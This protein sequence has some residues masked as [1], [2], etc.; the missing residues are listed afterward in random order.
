MGISYHTVML[1]IR[2]MGS[3][4]LI[5]MKQEMNK[6]HDAKEG[7]EIDELWSFVNSKKKQLWLWLGVCRKTRKIISFGQYYS[8]ITSSFPA[9]YFT[10]AEELRELVKLLSEN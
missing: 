1:W 2:E 5:K 8:E 6:Q 3:K 4:E 9:S 10:W 7:V